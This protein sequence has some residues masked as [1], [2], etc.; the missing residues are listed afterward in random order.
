MDKNR[1]ILVSLLALF[2]LCA[3]LAVVNTGLKLQ[4]Q[5]EMGSGEILPAAFMQKTG[6]GVGVVR[7]E[8]IIEMS[9]SS[10]FGI[11][12]GSD[13]A[14]ELIDS[15]AS[16]SSIKAVVVRINSPGG[17]VAA[18]QEIYRSLTEL[19]KTKPVV[20]SLGDIA[21]SGGYYA[22]SACSH[23]FVNP[24]TMTGSI[25]VIAT[26]PNLKKLFEKL[27]IEMNVIKSG[28]YKDI[29]SSSRNMTAEEQ[30]IIQKMIDSG[31]RQF[32]ADVA[33]GRGKTEKEILDVADGRI[34]DG[35][36][37]V[38]AGLADE[39]GSFRD[40]V[41]KAGELAGLPENFP[42]YD[43]SGN[44]MNQLILSITNRISGPGLLE[45]EKSGYYRI[46]YRYAQ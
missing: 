9:D 27:G 30:Q 43:G 31:Y 21:A 28:K 7:I 32:V 40:A 1:K 8:G 36:D 41:A 18:T 45:N 33:A 26:S 17:T 35:T 10:G 24:G 3:V 16:D 37:A 2:V 15:Y 34:M 29:M 38:K 11:K 4:K 5:E 39:T 22:A 23:I 12:T 25:G 6:P 46:E 19:R 20:A 13:A 42:V 14:V 44:L